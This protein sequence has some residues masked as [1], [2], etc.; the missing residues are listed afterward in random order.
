MASFIWKEHEMEF[1]PYL[2][3]LTSYF[4]TGERVYINKRETKG[5]ENESSLL[6]NK[7]I[8]R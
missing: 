4:K 2:F 5:I 6:F 8:K 7:V 3:V 1:Y